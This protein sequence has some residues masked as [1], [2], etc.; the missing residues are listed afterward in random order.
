M[1]DHKGVE[2]NLNWKR[3]PRDKRDF[4]L[5]KMFKAPM[6]ALPAKTDLRGFCSKVE[7]QGDIGSCTG[8]AVAGAL[9]FLEILNGP[10]TCYV[11][12]SR[13]FL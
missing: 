12:K 5:R 8:N 6:E 1:K 3:M 2:R 10:E 11:E 7:D 9:E 13:L 4:G